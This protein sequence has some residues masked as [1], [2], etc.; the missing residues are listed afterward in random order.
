[1]CG[2]N[3]RARRMRRFPA[4][5]PTLRAGRASAAPSPWK[6]HGEHSTQSTQPSLLDD[7]QRNAGVESA[8]IATIQSTTPGPRTP[9]VTARRRSTASFAPRQL[10]RQIFQTRSVE[11]DVG[12][13]RGEDQQQAGENRADGE[14]DEQRD[15][16]HPP[17]CLEGQK[18]NCGDQKREDCADHVEPH[19]LMET[20]RKVA[21]YLFGIERRLFRASERPKRLFAFRSSRRARPLERESVV[22]F[23]RP[24]YFSSAYSTLAFAA[25]GFLLF[26]SPAAL[27]VL[28]S[29]K[30]RTWAR[31]AVG[32][33]R[34]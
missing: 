30:S 2:R 12:D 7:R 24:C 5:L 17:G 10:L 13:D 32:S 33:T 25:A 31:N 15:G 3:R 16:A 22:R 19:R 4:A 26:F 27:A 21:R 11:Q 34:S 28:P 18:N 14:Q 9:S 20:V 6:I 23:S 8:S 29:I 1:M